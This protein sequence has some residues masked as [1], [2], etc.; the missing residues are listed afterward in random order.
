MIDLEIFE[1]EAAAHKEGMKKRILWDNKHLA[2]PT[3]RYYYGSGG[4]RWAGR[5]RK[6]PLRNWK[7]RRR[8]RHQWKS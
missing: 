3:A 4:R 7:R 8:S 2:P 5:G 6:A 1:D